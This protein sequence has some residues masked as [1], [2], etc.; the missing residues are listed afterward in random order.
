MKRA[1]AAAFLSKDTAVDRLHDVI[2][3]SVGASADKIS[4]YHG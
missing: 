4:S 3:Q 1:G 2:V